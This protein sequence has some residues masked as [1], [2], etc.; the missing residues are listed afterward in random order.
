MSSG[1]TI[2]VNGPA[3]RKGYLAGQLSSQ[4]LAISQDEQSAE[5]QS[6]YNRAYNSNIN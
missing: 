3:D 4:V 1:K 5:P 2:D 6:H